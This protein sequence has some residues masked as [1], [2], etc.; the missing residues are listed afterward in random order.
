MA[1]CRHPWPINQPYREHIVPKV[2]EMHIEPV[3]LALVR[4][5]CAQFHY[6]GLPGNAAWRWGL[7]SGSNLYGV[8]AY[9]NGTRGLGASILG[10]EH[11]RKVW[12]I[13]RIVMSED[14]PTNSESRI[15][16]LSLREIHRTRPDVWAVVTFA[17]E[18]MGHIGTIYQ[19]TNAIYTGTTDSTSGTARLYF[20]NKAG[21]IRSWRSIR[22][23]GRSGVDGWELQK[24][25]KPKH[26]YV[27]V[28]GTSR[29]RRQRLALLK[30]PAIA[31]PERVA[32]MNDQEDT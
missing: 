27:Y 26:R 6:T 1:A 7:Y 12:H 8:I 14:A 25:T 10:D 21:Q 29:Q 24:A 23:A 31:Y 15:I 28:L 30:F 13:G 20:K 17:D 22:E 16:G 11:A 2:S 32:H 9:N 4:E 18:E 5:F 3:S 19:A